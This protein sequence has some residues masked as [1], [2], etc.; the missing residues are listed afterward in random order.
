VPA[1][2][3]GSPQGQPTGPM[4]GSGNAA[5]ANPS[6]EGGSS[7]VGQRAERP[8]GFVAG[9]PYE[10][11]PV[12]RPPTSGGEP[13]APLRPGEW[14]ESPDYTPPSKQDDDRDDKRRRRDIKSMAETRGRDWGLRNAAS[15]SVATTRPIR[16]DCYPDRIVLVPD[17]SR[18][19]AKVIPLSGGTEHSIDKLIAAVWEYMDS[20]GIAGRGMY[21]KPIL[22]IAVAPGAEQRFEELNVLLE[23]SGLTVRRKQ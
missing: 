5:T 3:A 6:S 18:V 12:R 10:P 16:V 22:S 11:Q 17:D 1:G 21:W 4:L 2:T 15:G 7:S 8:D 14:H 9:R 19:A 13:A 20:W 23:G